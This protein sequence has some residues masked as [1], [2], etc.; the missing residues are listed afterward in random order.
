MVYIIW[1]VRWKLQGVS[2]IVSKCRELWST[3][4]LKLD[5]H[6]TPPPSVNSAGFLLIYLLQCHLLH[7]LIFCS[8]V[9]DKSEILL[10]YSL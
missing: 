1:Q 10:I 9:I 6:F 5:R 7:L 8:I 2:Y 4:T 3:T